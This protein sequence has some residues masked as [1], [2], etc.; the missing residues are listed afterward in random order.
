VSRHWCSFCDFIHVPI[1]KLILVLRVVTF[2]SENNESQ[3]EASSSVYG[4]SSSYSSEWTNG[5]NPLDAF[6][7][8]HCDTYQGLWMWDLAMTCNSGDDKDGECICTWTELLMESGQLDCQDIQD[9][10]DDCDVCFA[11]LRAVGCNDNGRWKKTTEDY[12]VIA[13]PPLLLVFLLVALWFHCAYNVFRRGSASIGLK[14]Q[15]MIEHGG[16]DRED[17]SSAGGSMKVWMVPDSFGDAHGKNSG[18]WLVPD[19]MS[20]TSDGSS[21][22]N[23]TEKGHRTSMKSAGTIPTASSMPSMYRPQKPK[24]SK[25]KG[26]KNL[27]V[28]FVSEL[29]RARFFRPSN[30]G[31]GNENKKESSYSSPKLRDDDEGSLFPDILSAL[32]SAAEENDAKAQKVSKPR[33]VACMADT[34]KPEKEKEDLE[35]ETKKEAHKKDPKGHQSPS[36]KPM[37]SPSLKPK[38]I[39]PQK[40][41]ANAAK[42]A[43]WAREI[44][45]KL[46]SK[47]LHPKPSEPQL[48]EEDT[49]VEALPLFPDILGNEELWRVPSK[50]EIKVARTSKLPLIDQTTEMHRSMAGPHNHYEKVVV[51]AKS[52][53]KRNHIPPVEKALFPAIETYGSQER[54]QRGTTADERPGLRTKHSLSMDN[55]DDTPDQ[56]RRQKIAA[57]ACAAITAAAVPSSQS[58]KKKLIEN[59]ELFAVEDE[60]DDDDDD[61]DEGADTLGDHSSADGGSS[62]S[63]SS[64]SAGASTL[65][66]KSTEDEDEDENVHNGKVEDDDSG[67]ALSL[68]DII[69][70]DSSIDESYEG[71]SATS[72]LSS[73]SFNVTRNEGEV[74]VFATP[75]RRAQLN[76]TSQEGSTDSDADVDADANAD[77]DLEA[78][79]LV[80][81]DLDEIQQDDNEEEEEDEEVQESQQEFT[82]GGNTS[83]DD[84][85]EI[86]ASSTSDT[87]DQSRSDDDDEDN[88]QEGGYKSNGSTLD[89]YSY[90]GG[91]VVRT[92]EDA[93]HSEE[94]D[95]EEEEEEDDD[96]NDNENDKEE[97]DN[98]EEECTHLYSLENGEQGSI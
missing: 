60:D 89:E 7:I 9:C 3:T 22:D 46:K 16:G 98:G 19:H 88:D 30:P 41:A 36:S 83:D 25:L 27:V 17:D 40:D 54:R 55:D 39:V 51:A 61:D 82:D 63:S 45:N 71:G 8:K 78:Y 23:D 32:D 75:S 5:I 57:A 4:A 52:T 49:K 11:C 68:G 1:A 97:G 96:D 43:S 21:T 72:S 86:S 42:K 28:G 6:N 90:T 67:S 24:P 65:S 37:Q 79:P 2:C 58:S 62:E 44:R 92:V 66:S 70:D 31:S 69:S 80:A 94:E 38:E 53:K 26:S 34:L 56:A 85:T 12:M 64:A 84:E 35:R 13:L 91:V 95:E 29:A 76:D 77:T 20:V 81:V 93:E 50:E 14:E 87:K 59:E 48:A 33:G 47:K 74:V 10:P 18:V 15:L 73:P